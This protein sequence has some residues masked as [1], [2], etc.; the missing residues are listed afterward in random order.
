MNSVFK[1]S[2][3]Y[4]KQ[5]KPHIFIYLFSSRSDFHMLNGAVREAETL[6]VGRMHALKLDIL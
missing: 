3:I 2:T 1:S 5:N 6:T 4:L